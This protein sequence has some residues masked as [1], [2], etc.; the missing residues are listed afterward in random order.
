MGMIGRAVSAFN[1]GLVR[2]IYVC[3][4]AL[5]LGMLGA[6]SLQVVLRYIFGIA[7]S[8]SEE[9]SLLM[10][11]WLIMLGVALGVREAFHV[12]MDILLNAL[13]A[14]AQAAIGWLI[15]AATGM[16]GCYLAW[17]GWRY[18]DGTRGSVSASIEYPVE[19]L[20]TAAP[21]C[22]VLMALFALERLLVGP[23]PA[24]TEDA[25]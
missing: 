4:A 11:T 25:P 2:V 19:M 21:V 16:A 6:I 12:R 7:L 3:V 22:G 15:M 20:Y 23:L 5:V 13:P 24:P 17:S 14:R 9:M 10:Q 1:H 8:W 18:V